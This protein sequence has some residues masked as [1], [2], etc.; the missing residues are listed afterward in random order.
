MGYAAELDSLEIAKLLLEHEGVS[1]ID[2]RNPKPWLVPPEFPIKPSDG[3]CPLQIACLRGNVEMTRLFLDRG[4]DYIAE[5]G[6]SFGPSVCA[7]RSGSPEISELFME[8]GADLNK[9]TDD[10]VDDTPL[11]AVGQYNKKEMANFYLH[12]AQT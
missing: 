9:M 10:W 6:G 3:P 1:D 7:A 11:M 2:H 5:E 4:A 8:C 12:E